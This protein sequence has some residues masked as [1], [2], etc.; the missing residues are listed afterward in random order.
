[1]SATVASPIIIKKYRNRR[2]Y[3]TANSRYVT[4]ADIEQLVVDETP[5]HVV[6]SDTGEDVT[7]FVLMQI[8]ADREAKTP[9]LL[10]T[11]FLTDLIRFYGD[12]MQVFVSLYLDS[13]MN[14]FVVQ[15]EQMRRYMR[16]AFP[17]HPGLAPFMR[18]GFQGFEGV[19]ADGESADRSR[20]AKDQE[21]GA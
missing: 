17:D 14:A 9:T 3:N 21:D 12:T 15:Q 5:F 19:D 20:S 2:L 7:R 13:A 16:T 11:P 6:S 8:I 10:P 18:L 1:M 4:L